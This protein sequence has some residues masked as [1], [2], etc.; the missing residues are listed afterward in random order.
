MSIDTPKIKSETEKYLHLT[1]KY[2]EG[3]GVDIGSQGCPVV[4]WAIQLEQPFEKFKHYT[5]GMDLP[6]SVH[7]QGDARDLPF[8]D[9]VLD[10]IHCSHV[11]EDWDQK[12]WPKVFAE[13]KRCLKRGGY[14]IVLVPEV[15]RWNEAIKRGQCPN[16]SH[17]APEPS[18]GDLSRAAHA[19]PGLKVL[20]DRM[21]DLNPE[22]YSILGVFQKFD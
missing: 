9:G 7:W 5:G 4:P 19:V 8:K 15:V 17:W 11:I 2:C 13:W 20:E 1:Q 21:T 18:V 10:W 6:E 14:I 12:T 16:C 22:D 3:N